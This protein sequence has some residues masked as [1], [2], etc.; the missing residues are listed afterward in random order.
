MMVSMVFFQTDPEK[1]YAKQIAKDQVNVVFD[2]TMSWY[3]PNSQYV[4]LMMVVGLV[5]YVFKRLGT[6]C[7]TL[8]GVSL[9]LLHVLFLFMLFPLAALFLIKDVQLRFSPVGEMGYRL[10]EANFQKKYRVYKRVT[11][12]RAT[13]MKGFSYLAAIYLALVPIFIY[14]IFS[15]TAG[16]PLSFAEL[17]Q[18]YI[19]KCEK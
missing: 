19:E 6:D 15:K 8:Y 5:A 9:L 11:P 14:L 1:R 7:Q 10:I 2:N 12:M 13:A 17:N 18:V 3:P 4:V 16:H